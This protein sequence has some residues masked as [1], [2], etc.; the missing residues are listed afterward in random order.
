MSL[1]SLTR[2]QQIAR[3]LYN[4]LA[5]D[6]VNRSAAWEIRRRSGMTPTQKGDLVAQIT[7]YLKDYS[8][9]DGYI[10]TVATGAVTTVFNEER[11][12]ALADADIDRWG[13]SAILDTNTCGPCRDADGMEGKRED[14]PSVPN[15]DC[16]G[17]LKCRC[18]HYAV[19]ASESKARA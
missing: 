16:E 19:L 15:P 4:L 6:I 17:G 11:D 14:L 7:Q 1:L 5:T 8:T 13:Y 3:G 10:K 12:A 9:P 2:L 18:I